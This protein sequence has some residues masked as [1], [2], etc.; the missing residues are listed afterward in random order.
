MNQRNTILLGA[1]IGGASVAFGA[2]GAHA[3]K[4]VLIS[5]GRSET[6]ELA[7]RYQFYH[8]LALILVGYLMTTHTS[9][10]LKGAAT[11]FAAGILL[12]C[13]SLYALCF[14]AYRIIG[15]ITP[16]GGLLFILGWALLFIAVY[17]EKKS[18]IE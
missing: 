3:L 10:L 18:L 8:A 13:G 6:Y 7:V 15:M 1:A 2:F 5:S 4:A 9:K 17:K 14:T 12:F 11:A 16:L